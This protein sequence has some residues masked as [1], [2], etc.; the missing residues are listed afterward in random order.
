MAAEYAFSTTM[1][2]AG[3]GQEIALGPVNR[4]A[5]S[6]TTG[7]DHV[8]PLNV[9]ARPAA[10]I[11]VQKVGRAHDSS[12]TPLESTGCVGTLQVEPFQVTTRFDPSTAAQKDA[13][14]QDSEKPAGSVSMG[15]GALQVAPLNVTERA[16]I[17][18]AIQK[19]SERHETEV[20]AASST[21]A[22]AVQEVP[23]NVEAY[24]L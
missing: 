9:I 22:A 10:S 19:V 24:R 2:N 12:T 6:M 21:R 7:A 1:Q 13:D 20:R 11:S 14:V 16:E 3:D 15:V 23:L 5:V 18:T 4:G 8:D 17:S